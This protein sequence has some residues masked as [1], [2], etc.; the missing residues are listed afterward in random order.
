MNALNTNYTHVMQNAE[1]KAVTN[2]KTKLSVAVDNLALLAHEIEKGF[3]D[4]R[5]IADRIYDI[6][7]ALR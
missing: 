4:H 6:R 5:T 2:L 1:S 3:T 7:E